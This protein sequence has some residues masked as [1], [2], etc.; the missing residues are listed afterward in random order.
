MVF[1]TKLSAQTNVVT[2]IINKQFLD[3]KSIVKNKFYNWKST[4]D[5]SLIKWNQIKELIV[6]FEKP[7]IL[8]IKYNLAS[9][10]FII[11]N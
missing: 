5:G 2:E 9:S 1:L 11:I 3:F 6:T 8:N 4:V 7:F 10:D